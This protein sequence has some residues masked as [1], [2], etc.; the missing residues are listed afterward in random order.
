MRTLAPDS[1]CGRRHY[2]IETSLNTIGKKN[3]NSKL[4]T[5]LNFFYIDEHVAAYRVQL[6]MKQ[7]LVD[8]SLERFLFFKLNI[9]YERV[10]CVCFDE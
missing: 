4:G 5:T 9:Q 7:K 2:D 1:D 6:I 8:E 3:T 10:G